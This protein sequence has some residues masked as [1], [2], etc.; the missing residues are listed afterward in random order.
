[1]VEKEITINIFGL[2]LTK[3]WFEKTTNEERRYINWSSAYVIRFKED[4]WQHLDIRV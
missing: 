2:K 4:D 1:M 3:D